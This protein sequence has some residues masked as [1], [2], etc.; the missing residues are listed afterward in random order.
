MEVF[1]LGSANAGSFAWTTTDNTCLVKEKREDYVLLLMPKASAW[2]SL[3]QKSLLFPFPLT[4]STVKQPHMEIILIIGNSHCGYETNIPRPPYW[5]NSKLSQHCGKT[6][7]L[8]I[9]DDS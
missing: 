2:T 4:V 5:P 9:E 7:S 1:T 8:L 6:I 3:V